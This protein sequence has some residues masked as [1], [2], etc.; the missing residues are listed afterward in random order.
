MLEEAQL[1]SQK[2]RR[3]LAAASSANAKLALANS[4]LED[5]LAHLQQKFEDEKRAHV[6][7]RKW[8]LPKLQKLEE[9]VVATGNAF[10]EVKL[11][12]ELVTNMYKVCR[13]RPDGHHRYHCS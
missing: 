12:V 9:T 7:G 2:L 13:S 3:E 11:S 1:A 10:H 6:N 5:D 8:F 4:Q